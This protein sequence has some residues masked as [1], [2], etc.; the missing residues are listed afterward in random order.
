MAQAGGA[1]VFLGIPAIGPP[2]ADA[3]GLQLDELGF[4]V[5]AL[6]SGAGVSVIA[7]GSL[8]DRV[9]E[10]RVMTAGFTVAALSLRVGLRPGA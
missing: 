5:A 3:Y 4:A 8:A 9:G 7:W 1:A 6:T 10:R 2:F